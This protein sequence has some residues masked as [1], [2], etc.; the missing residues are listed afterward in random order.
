MTENVFR[1]KISWFSFCFSLLVVWVHSYNAELFLG[2]TEAAEFVYKIEHMLGDCLGQIAVPGFFM[3]S[4]YLFYRNFRWDMLRGKWDRRIRSILVPYILWNF[5]YYMG[6]VAGSR[7][8]WVTDVVGKGTIPFTLSSTVDAVVNHTYNYVF[9]Y[10]YQL[11]GLT[12]LAPVLYPLLKQRWRRISLMAVLWYLVWKDISL[13]A[14]NPDALIYYGT[15]AALAIMK[16]ENEFWD[17]EQ[18]WTPGRAFTGGVLCVAGG[19]LYYQ[20]LRLALIPGF[21]LCRLFFVSGLWLMVP[22]EKLPGPWEFME[23]SFFFYAVHFAFVRLINKTAAI[24]YT[25]VLWEPLLL[26][27]FMPLIIL[28]ISLLLGKI[29]KRWMPVFWKLLNGFR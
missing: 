14:V 16:E 4:G 17:P 25:D 21:V 3:I 6:Y 27:F 1:K 18:S 29:L 2:H 5:L 24:F 19:W 23:D 12:V 22:E 13:P 9:W 10:L 15:G 20:S 8:P 28:V 7:L 26:F 11:I